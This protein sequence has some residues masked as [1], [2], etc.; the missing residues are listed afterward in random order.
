MK[1]ML[2]CIPVLL[3]FSFA[4]F[5]TTMAVGQNSGNIPFKYEELTAPDFITAVERSGATC[6]IPIGVLEKHGPHLPLGTDL[7]DVRVVA[8]RAAE[9]EYVVVFP[10]YYFGQI[11]EAKHQPGTIAYSQELQWKLLQET[12]DE[13]GRNGFKNIVLVNGHGG[14]NSF[15]PYF[16]QCQ[17]AERKDYVV[18]FFRPQDDPEVTEKVRKLRKTTTGGH[19]GETEVSTM[20]VHRPDIVHPDRASQQSGENQRRMEHIPYAFT[21]I[22]WYAMYPNHY[23]GDGSQASTEIGELLIGSEVDQ[24][25]TLIRTLKKDDTALRLQ[26]RFFDESEQPLKTRQ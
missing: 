10:E 7:L 24:L 26:N 3:V 12:C 16:C 18:F 21:G 15:L 8:S 9:K 14:N 13:L 2:C 5:F 11:L 22:G 19:A 20:L 6:L 23:A 17:L 1:R 25:V 4:M